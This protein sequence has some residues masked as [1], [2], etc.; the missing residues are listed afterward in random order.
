MS[1]QANYFKLGLFVIVAATLL[2]AG[3]II[4]G[5]GKLAARTITVETYMTESVEGISKGSA[6]KY[7]GIELGQVG[8]V[9]LATRKY[10]PNSMKEGRF[11]TGVLV[12][13]AISQAALNNQSEAALKSWLPKAV[14]G[15]LRARTASSGLTGPPFIELVFLDASEFPPPE[16][17][18]KPPVLYIPSAPSAVQVLVDQVQGILKKLEK[19]DLL[20]VLAEA[21]TLMKS[22]N[23]KIDDLNV[24]EIN[25]LVT[26][27]GE[28]LADPRIESLL[29]S[30]NRASAELPPALEDARRTLLSIDQLI[31]AQKGPIGSVLTDLN[32]TLKNTEA[33]TE[34]ASQNPSR[35]I[36]GRPPP[37]FKPKTKP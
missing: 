31:Q 30:L 2:C 33:I 10:D 24:K 23:T 13:L 25:D 37:P 20:P 7:R 19:I 18:W 9:I 28:L 35:I 5:G 29:T 22:V 26:H 15:G 32:R 17:A 6:V 21:E 36:F 1:A 4:L 27:L 11:G 12:E 16:I 8:S 3:V 14:A 34:D